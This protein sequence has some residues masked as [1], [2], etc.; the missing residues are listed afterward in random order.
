MCG[1]FILTCPL[2]EIEAHFDFDEIAASWEPR[3]NIAPSQP[4]LA[5][6]QEEDG[7]RRLRTFRWGLIPAWA[8]DERIGNRLINARAESVGEKP[9]FR[10][11]F[12]SRRCLILGNG[13][14]EWKKAGTRKIPFLIQLA[15]KEPF[16]MAGLWERWRAPDGEEVRSCTI[17]T[18]DANEAIAPIHPRMPVILPRS[19]HGTWLDPG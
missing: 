13:F 2:S 10:A 5:I 16:A 3:Y 12:R 4:V 11:A 15:S 8:K 18:T 1:R 7:Q 9:S 6:V 14:Y 19:A 17:L